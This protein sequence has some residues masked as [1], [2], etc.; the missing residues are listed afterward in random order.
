MGSPAVDKKGYVYYTETAPDLTVGKL[1]K[2]NGEGVK[3]A[4]LT[5]GQS[6]CTSPT[7]GPDGTVYC[8]GIKDGKPT[9]SAIGGVAE[10]ASGW[11]QF[12]GN[13]RKTCKAE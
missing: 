11:S 1:V 12:G 6:L 3:V 13:P 8:N 10:P 5:L 7:L 9:L 4:E 2:L